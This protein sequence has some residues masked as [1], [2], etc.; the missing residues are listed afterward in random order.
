[1]TRLIHF[2]SESRGD[3]PAYAPRPPAGRPAGEPLLVPPRCSRCGGELATIADDAADFTI[4]LECP[5][6]FVVGFNFGGHAS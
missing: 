2:P 5:G 3:R 1:M 6:G 4:C